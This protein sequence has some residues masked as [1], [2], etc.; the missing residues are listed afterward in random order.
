MEIIIRNDDGT[1]LEFPIRELVEVE[2]GNTL[3]FFLRSSIPQD[4]F[5][6]LK[7]HLESVSGK[8]VILLGP[9]FEQK[10]YQID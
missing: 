8:N 7:E 6:S 5:K 2:R 3:V 1:E 10:V 4:S 9:G